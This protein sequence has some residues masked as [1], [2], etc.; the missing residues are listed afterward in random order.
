MYHL[1]IHSKTK[2]SI[3]TFVVKFPLITFE[4]E[5][6]QLINVIALSLKKKLKREGVQHVQRQLLL[7]VQL[8]SK[9]E[10]NIQTNEERNDE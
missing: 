6:T 7:N 1:K 9:P 4:V 5:N 10:Q 8:W 2:V 3:C